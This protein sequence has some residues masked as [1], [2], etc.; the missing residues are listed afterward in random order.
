MWPT[1]YIPNQPR[2]EGEPPPRYYLTSPPYPVEITESLAA[3]S[4]DPDAYIAPAA[5]I[6]E[7]LTSSG[8]PVD[9]LLKDI[10]IRYEEWPPEAL[11]ST[12]EPVSGVLNDILVRYEGPPESLESSGE[13]VS[14]ALVDMLVRYENWPLGVA[15][16]SLS[17][18]GAPVS[19]VLT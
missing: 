3:S 5:E 17:S 14:G 15:T 8:A 6:E 16:E 2:I 1:H 4:D 10:L 7:T 12:G 13:P 19:G 9:G 18:S 11:E